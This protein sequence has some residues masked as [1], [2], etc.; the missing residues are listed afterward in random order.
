MPKP[1][2]PVSACDP[3]STA[4]PLKIPPLPGEIASSWIVRAARAYDE[5][6]H[7]FARFVWGALPVWTRDCDATLTHDAL[8]ELGHRLNTRS[9]EATAT[10]LR[11]FISRLGGTNALTPG[12]LRIGVF[13]RLRR[14]HGQ[15]YC[16]VCISGDQKRYL[17]RDWR[18]AFMVS[19]PEHGCLLCDACPDCD[20]PITAHRTPDLQVDCC[21]N[22]EAQ[23]GGQPVGAPA[24]VVYAQ[25]SIWKHWE[26]GTVPIG[27]DVIS[28]PDWLAG[29]RILFRA[30][31]RQGGDRRLPKAAERIF[32]VD[33]ARLS[34]VG[35]LE[36]SRVTDRATLLPAA[37]GLVDAWPERLI[38]VCTDAGLRLGD[39]ID[40][41]REKAPPWMEAA[42]A[43][44]PHV[45]RPRRKMRR[46]S[47][48]L[49]ISVAEARHQ[50]DLASTIKD[51][52]DKLE[53]GAEP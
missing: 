36:H 17:R 22:C 6:P 30:L 32:E 52:L 25:R 42:I 1:R 19:C 43:Q 53:S 26:S 11:P 27:D 50:I 4:W 18:L 29:I 41:L 10:G 46:R 33:P 8:C 12:L 39:L 35:P 48:T 37:V 2:C 28:F 3:P 23:L 51:R 40:P 16:P 31:G 45:R 38:K 13:H 21:W 24:A 15:Q 20:A 34:K 5:T 7:A 9:E 49:D 14:R 44:L 47:G